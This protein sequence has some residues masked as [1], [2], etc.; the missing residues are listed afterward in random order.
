MHLTPHQLTFHK[1]FK[2]TIS[3]IGK[4]VYTFCFSEDFISDFFVV[5]NGLVQQKKS[6]LLIDI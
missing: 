2:F 1:A 5:K 4:K 6:L 3:L